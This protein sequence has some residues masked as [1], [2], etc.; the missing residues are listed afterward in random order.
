MT[1]TSPVPV[2]TPPEQY[3]IAGH[4]VRL[5]LCVAA[6]W[7]FML[8]G[9]LL[10]TG[11]VVLI[12]TVV[13]LVMLRGLFG[14]ARIRRRAWRNAYL[15]PESPWN[16]RLRGGM[17]LFII[18]LGKASVLA[19]VLLLTVVRI[20]DE[21]EVWRLMLVAVLLFA[22]ARACADRVF[23]RDVSPVYRPE[24]VARVGQW[25][26]G[27]V[28]VLCLLLL[29]LVQPQPDFREATLEQALWHVTDR[30][31]AASVVVE[32]GTQWVAAWQGAEQWLAQQVTALDQPYWFR[33]GVW[34]SVLVRQSLFVMALLVLFNGVLAE[35]LRD[36][37]A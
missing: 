22:L 18:Q 10:T 25:S 2:N 28:L 21:P 7:L 37:G 32:K 11:W 15:Y 19:A 8:E 16:R 3:R 23:W 36:G 17:C 27:I 6:L 4:A 20:G 29:A 12:W 1:M 14:R 33:A 34:V 35:R 26:A 24:L 30:E 5:L 31:A 13:T 9:R